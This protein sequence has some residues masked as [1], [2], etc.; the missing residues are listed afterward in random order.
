MSRQPF[1]YN[2][3]AGSRYGAPMG[4]PAIGGELE[5]GEPVT[6]RSV[7][8]AQGYDGGGAYWGDRP[9]G[10]R[11]FCIW[12]AART[13]IRFVDAASAHAARLQLEA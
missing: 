4:R 8:M 13:F 3:P 11:L 5:P 12:N 2:V 10:V 9:A 6:V 7:P 1:P